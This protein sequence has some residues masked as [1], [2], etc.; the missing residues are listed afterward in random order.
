MTLFGLFALSGIDD[1]A[2][3]D[4]H[5]NQDE[6]DGYILECPDHHRSGGHYRVIEGEEFRVTLYTNLDIGSPTGGARRSR[7]R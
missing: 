6:P 5:I 2:W 1:V 3:A 4:S 7:C